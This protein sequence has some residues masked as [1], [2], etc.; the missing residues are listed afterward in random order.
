M[1]VKTW[2]QSEDHIIILVHTY[3]ILQQGHSNPA[4]ST[5]GVQVEV[6]KWAIF[7]NYYYYFD[8]AFI[9]HLLY[10]TAVYFTA[11]VFEGRLH[12]WASVRGKQVDLKEQL[13][14]DWK[15]PAH[16]EWD[17]RYVALV[18][19]HFYDSKAFPLYRYRERWRN[20]W[21]GGVVSGKWSTT[22]IP[23]YSTICWYLLTFYAIQPF[24]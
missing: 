22:R 12:N 2:K 5:H 6:G 9:K 20:E 21:G 15:S 19:Y 4:K 11:A 14:K 8:F 18:Q 23:T 24:T 16:G 10:L 7:T 3:S 1:M 17:E 13:K